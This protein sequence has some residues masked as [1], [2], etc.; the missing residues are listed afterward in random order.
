MAWGRVPAGKAIRLVRHGLTDLTGFVLAGSRP[1]LQLD[2]RGG[3]EAA[4]GAARLAGL[5]LDA[6][7]SSPLERCRE[8][9]E[10]V[11]AVT[12]AEKVEIDERF[13]EVHHGDWTRRPLAE[14]GKG[15]ALPAGRPPPRA[16]RLPRARPVAPA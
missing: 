10:A 1:E 16:L 7:V 11:A 15:P 13:G 2:D 3:A 8:T 4:A 5:P 9:A 14:L 6:L 12:G